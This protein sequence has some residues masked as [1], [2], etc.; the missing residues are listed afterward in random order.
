MTDCGC[1]KAKAELEEYLHDELCKEDAADIREHM[2][3]C[4]DCSSELRVGQVLTDAVK[5]AC[6][7]QAPE[8]IRDQVLAR[9]RDVQAGHGSPVAGI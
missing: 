8:H 2:A 7:E 3:H 4:E 6:R 1:D 5:R 9:I